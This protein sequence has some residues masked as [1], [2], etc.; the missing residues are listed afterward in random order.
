MKIARELASLHVT[1]L[2]VGGG[3]GGGGTLPPGPRWLRPY[4]WL[5]WVCSKKWTMRGV[6]N[7]MALVRAANCTQADAQL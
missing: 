1:T 5:I 6:L 2:G 3:G 7:L 4:G